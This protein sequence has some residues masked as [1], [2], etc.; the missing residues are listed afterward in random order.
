MAQVSPQYC[1]RC[2]AAVVPQQKFCATC[3]LPSAA[4]N[5]EQAAP[6]PQSM[7]VFAGDPQS[8]VSQP[9][10]QQQA[11]I[12][13][14]VIPPRKRRIG[15]NGIVL[16]LIALL[17]VIIAVVYGLLQSLGVGKPTQASIS[18]TSINTTVTYAS[19]DMTILN[20]QQSQNFLDDPASASNGM[21]RVQIQTKNS[22]TQPV[23]LAYKNIAHLIQPGGKDGAAVYV[24]S[25]AAI[26][27]GATQTSNIDFALPTNIKIDQLSLRLGA[28]NEAQLD[29]PLNGH[30]DVSKYAPK[31]IKV[32]KSL[33]YLNMNWTLVDASSQLS[34]NGQQASKGM[35][36]ITVTFN[37]DNPLME[38][39]IPGSPYT[40]MHL[41]ANTTQVAPIS[42]DMPVSIDA[43][44][45]GK[46]GMATFQIPQG[47]STLTL[48]LSTQGNSGFD[49]ATATFQI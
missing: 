32:A 24:S 25:N 17:L 42:A 7:P 1:P 48:A 3:G 29:I 2:G 27:P 43:G 6:P 46:T 8:P 18:K 13:N 10:V 39:V 38:T 5:F 12:P 9:Q 40:Y 47:S 19:V 20:A 44:V 35:R 41:Q 34:L 31:T 16:L 4:Q 11:F 21:L 14:H 15:R 26:A 30:A 37:V 33:T 49:P 45:N 22:F 36:Y 23:T 28:A